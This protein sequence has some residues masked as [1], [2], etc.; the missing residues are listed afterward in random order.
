MVIEYLTSHSEHSVIEP[1]PLNT[2]IVVQSLPSMVYASDQKVVDEFS[3]CIHLISLCLD[4]EVLKD[5]LNDFITKLNP[6]SYHTTLIVHDSYNMDKE[7]EKAFYPYN[8][9]LIP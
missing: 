8:L 5:S 3:P 9:I 6:P 7:E 4:V 1:L 2:S